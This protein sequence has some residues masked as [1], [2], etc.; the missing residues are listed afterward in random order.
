MG[1]MVWDG[2]PWCQFVDEDEA[3]LRGQFGSLGSGLLSGNKIDPRV[4]EEVKAEAR[5]ILRQKLSPKDEQ[6]SIEQEPL[7]RAA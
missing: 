5:R 3:Y 4:V 1:K 7:R 6:H 2:P